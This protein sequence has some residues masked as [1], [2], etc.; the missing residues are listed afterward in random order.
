MNRNSDNKLLLIHTPTLDQYKVLF[1][2]NNRD[3]CT[4]PLLKLKAGFEELGYTVE[5]ANRQLLSNV[6]GVIFWD[7]SHIY[8]GFRPKKIFQKA[9]EYFWV[10]KALNLKKTLL[11]IWEGSARKQYGFDL[12]NHQGFKKILTWN[13][14]LIDNRRYFKFFLPIP[15]SWPNTDS[16]EFNT[17]KLLVNISY[18]KS[19][20]H[21]RELYSERLKTIEYFDK[22][23]SSS[24]DLYGYGWHKEE[25]QTYRGIAKKKYEVLQNYKF[26][27]CYENL[28]DEK[29]YVTEKIFD[30][31]RS[32]CVPIYWGASNIHDYVDKEAFIDRRNFNTNEELS[33]YINHVSEED[34]MN[35]LTAIGDYIKSKKFKKFLSTSFVNNIIKHFE[36]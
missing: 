32:N 6:H 15:E 1:N 16:R 21:P 29:G 17:K 10:K 33:N 9:R 27:L 24:F 3:N 13:D 8:K 4:E 25:F 31:M 18:N 12:K 35:Y 34:Y 28:K 14:S 23:Y 36:D 2:V 22:Y 19:S 20:S 7:S 30:C 26:S 5:H 11:I